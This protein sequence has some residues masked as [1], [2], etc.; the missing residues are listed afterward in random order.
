MPLVE[1]PI[2]RALTIPESDTSLVGAW[3]SWQGRTPLVDMS[4]GGANGTGTDVVLGSGRA[5]CNGT[6]SGISVGDKDLSVT[7]AFTISAWVQPTSVASYNGVIGKAAYAWT[8]QLNGSRLEMH[9]WND[10]GTAEPIL[11]IGTSGLVTAGAWHYVTVTYDG[12]GTAKSYVNGALDKTQTGISEAFKNTAA[13]AVIGQGYNNGSNR[14]LAGTIADVRIYNRALS[15]SEIA[16]MYAAGVPDAT[17]RLAVDGRGRDLSRFR[18]TVTPTSGVTLGRRIV[19]D[20]TNGM[21]DAGDVGN[22]TEVSFWANPTAVTQQLFRVD[23]GKSV[24]TSGS[25]I[26]YT[27]LTATGTYVDGAAGTTLTA[28]KWSHV[29]CQFAQVDANNL[30]LGTDGTDYGAC[31]FDQ[32]CVRTASRAA[33]PI[34]IEY[35]QTRGEF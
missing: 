29:V 13:A 12:A 19:C 26:T 21:L 2:F 1:M 20:G 9:T 24:S 3:C 18:T 10:G 15:A 25:T 31:S 11:L 17:L 5:T 7:T 28:G 32:W 8:V 34:A 22:I 30:E 35:L 4:A 14:F 23:T 33:A 27:G 6:T 16:A